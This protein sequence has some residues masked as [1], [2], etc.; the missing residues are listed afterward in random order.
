MRL[1]AAV[2]PPAA[3]LD[4]LGHVVDRLHRLPGADGLRWTSR[5][6]WHLTL[7]FMGEV[8]EEL[9]PELRVRLARAAHRTP[10]F[11]L[12]LHGG[13][14]FGRRALWTGVAGDLDDL[15]LLAERADA[16]ARRAGVP[17]DEHRRYQAHLTLARARTDEVDLHP[18]LDEFGT[19]EGARWEVGELALVR[20][21]LPVSGVRGEQP[22][23][24]QI[25]GWPLEGRGEG[26]G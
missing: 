13:G 15:R 17:M 20:S 7:A 16:A 18:F 6:G 5:P 10:P 4:E 14:H 3:R 26:A 24:E 23:Y 22:R 8:D 25:G 9:L 1:F 21:N 19:F 12:R 11:P 2:L